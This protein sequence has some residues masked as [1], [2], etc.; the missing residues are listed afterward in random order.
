MRTV[1][2]DSAGFRA[3]ASPQLQVATDD[4][5]EKEKRERAETLAHRKGN[6]NWPHR[7]IEEGPKHQGQ[8]NEGEDARNS[9]ELVARREVKLQGAP[10]ASSLP[11]FVIG[12]ANP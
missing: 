9:Q 1:A 8:R 3:E 12:C 2:D 11:S 7:R 4:D 10:C 6:Q 5:E